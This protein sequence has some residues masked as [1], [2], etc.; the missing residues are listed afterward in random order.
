[1]LK[2]MTEVAAM[3]QIPY[4]TFYGWVRYVGTVPAP[5]VKR[6]RRYFYDEAGVEA[7]RAVISQ[8][9]V[10]LGHVQDKR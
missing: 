7:V 10:R 5:R 2:T 9:G 6:G 1:M 8:G 4:P 3:L